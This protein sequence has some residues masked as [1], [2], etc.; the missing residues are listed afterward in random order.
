MPNIHSIALKGNNLSYKYCCKYYRQCSNITNQRIGL[1]G[2]GQMGSKIAKKL[3][4][5]QFELIIYDIHQPNCQDVKEINPLKVSILPC[6]HDISKYDCSTIISILPNDQIVNIVSSE[7][8]KSYDQSLKQPLIHISCSTI[9]PK[10][11]KGLEAFYESNNAIYISAPV[12]ARPDGLAKRQATWM[13]SG[14][15]E[16][17]RSIAKSLLERLGNVHDFGDDISAANVVKLCGNFLIASSIESIGEVMALSEKHNV[18]REKVMN[19]LSSTIF[20]CLIYQGYGQ[21]VSK[22]DHRPGGFSLELGLKDVSLVSQAARDV[23]VPM[24]ILSI[25]LDRFTSA[26]AKGRKDFD[27]SAIGLNIAEDAGLNIDQDLHRNI[28]NITKNNKYE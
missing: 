1:I 28:E 13:T 22:R 7:I 27:W 23:D 26:K 11:A 14:K 21:R 8:L 6:I 3:L 25:L 5:D 12:F 2:L 19:L 16:Y 10:T 17:G 20:N 18:D 15:S 4:E 24:P 9:S